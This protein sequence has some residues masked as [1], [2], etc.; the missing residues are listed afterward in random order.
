MFPGELLSSLKDP[1]LAINFGELQVTFDINCLTLSVDHD[2]DSPCQ[3]KGGPFQRS[4]SNQSQASSGRFDA[5]ETQSNA[6]S[7]DFA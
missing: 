6:A 4:L 7:S 3:K 5:D 2:L 1:L